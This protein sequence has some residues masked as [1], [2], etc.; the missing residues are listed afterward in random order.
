MKQSGEK[1]ID[2]HPFVKIFDKWANV[3][4]DELEKKSHTEPKTPSANIA[5]ELKEEENFTKEDEENYARLEKEIAELEREISELE[6]LKINM[7]EEF[8]REKKVV[9]ESAPVEEDIPDSKETGEEHFKKEQYQSAIDTIIM[10][11]YAKVFEKNNGLHYENTFVTNA[12]DGVAQKDVIYTEI[13]F[14]K[15]RNSKKFKF[16]KFEL[17]S[18]NSVAHL[19]NER[20]EV[21]VF[22]KLSGFDTE[23][24]K[25]ICGLIIQ[26]FIKNQR[27]GSEFKINVKDGDL[28]ITNQT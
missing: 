25:K 17:K 18:Q 20:W 12:K 16:L 7:G 1:K 2:E 21:G 24:A 15:G 6:N 5:E 8:L 26:D 4:K 10:N 22:D 14:S 23:N 3:T 19:M 28:I 9:G 11:K 13:K 27:K